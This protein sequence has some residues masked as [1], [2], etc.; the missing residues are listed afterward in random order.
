MAN[1][2]AALNPNPHILRQMQAQQAEEQERAKV[3]VLDPDFLIMLSL[4]IIIDI[5]DWALGF[6]ILV[7]FVAGLPIV[8]WMHWRQSKLENV[9]GKWAQSAKAMNER[10]AGKLP[11]KGLGRIMSK[12]R[13]TKSITRKAALY[14]A[15]AIPV[16]NLLPLWSF[17][18]ILMLKNK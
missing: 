17:A 8:F 15:E 7:G 4:A 2:T 13:L 16:V 14:I 12:G 9:K 1:G 10:V 3:F 6:G 11:T 5:L 18:I